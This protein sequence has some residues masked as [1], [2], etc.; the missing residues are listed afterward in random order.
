M[1]G[2]THDQLERNL[3]VTVN[4][5]EGYT[6]F[7]CVSYDIMLFCL[8]PNISL[9]VILFTFMSWNAALLKSQMFLLFDLLLLPLLL[10]YCIYFRLPLIKH[11]GCFCNVTETILN[12]SFHSKISMITDSWYP[13]YFLLFSLWHIH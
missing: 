8:I 11:G 12:V 3:S 9:P 4:W 13:I 5:L 7:V 10:P 1:S 6:S 2:Q